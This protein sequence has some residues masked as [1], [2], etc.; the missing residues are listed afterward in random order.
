[1]FESTPFGISDAMREKMGLQAHFDSNVATHRALRERGIRFA[2]G[3]DYGLPWQPHGHNARDI[4][5]MMRHYELSA[6]EAQTA[7][8]RHGAIAA[9]RADDLGLLAPGHRADLLLVEGDPL[10]DVTRLQSPENFRAIVQ[11]G[12]LSRDRRSAARR[13]QAGSHSS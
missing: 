13:L 8:T 1:M 5:L 10:S 2:I 11:A 7:A 3:G 6:V 12:R 4:E 9:G